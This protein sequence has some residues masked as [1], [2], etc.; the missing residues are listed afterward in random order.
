MATI[1]TETNT[2]LTKR[3]IANANRRQAKYG[4][5]EPRNYQTWLPHIQHWLKLRLAWIEY[6]EPK[7]FVQELICIN[8]EA[9]LHGECA[10]CSM[11]Q[12]FHE[13]SASYL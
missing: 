13:R 6:A 3:Q 5:V 1:N 12:Y 10:D 8:C 2:A 4:K 11:E 9:D 7:G